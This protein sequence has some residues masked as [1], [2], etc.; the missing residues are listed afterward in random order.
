MRAGSRRGGVVLVV[1]GLLAVVLGGQRAVGQPCEGPIFRGQ[2]FRVGTD[3]FSIAVGDLT[4]DGLPDIVAANSGDNSISVLINDGLGGI[5]S[6]EDY[7]AGPNPWGVALGDIDGDGD[8]DVAAC[9]RDGQCPSVVSVWVNDGTGGLAGRVDTPVG[10]TPRAVDFGDVDG[11]GDFDLAIANDEDATATVLANDGAG[12]FTLLQTVATGPRPY[13]IRLTDLDGDGDADLITANRDGGSLTVSLNDGGVFDGG[14]NYPANAQ[15]QGLDL[16]DLDSDGDVDALVANPIDRVVSVLMNNGTGGFAAPT[17]L[18]G[19]EGASSVRAE[20]ANGDGRPDL[21][22]CGSVL[23]VWIGDGAG[24]FARRAEYPAGGTFSALA[25]GDMD[26]DGDLDALL[27]DLTAEAVSILANDGDGGFA[28]TTATAVDGGELQFFALFDL[29]GDGLGEAVTIDESRSKL[30]VYARSGE[31]FV[32]ADRREGFQSIYEAI[33]GE[34][35][36][37]D[38][39]DLVLAEQDADRVVVLPGNGDG[40][41]GSPIA[42][43]TID[44]PVFLD[45]GDMDGDGRL[46][47]V[48]LGADGL[49]V[50]LNDGGGTL[51]PAIP[52]AS[53]GEA[54]SVSV[55]DVDGDGHLDVVS[56]YGFRDVAVYLGDGTGALAF[57]GLT[58]VSS[59]PQAVTAV[60][61][62]A[63]GA[64]DVVAVHSFRGIAATLMSRGDGTLEPPVELFGDQWADLCIADIDEDGDLDVLASAY[65]SGLVSVLENDGEGVLRYTRG[66][67]SGD[68]PTKIGCVSG[69]FGLRVN[70]AVFSPDTRS[71]ELLKVSDLCHGCPADL[72]GDGALTIFD[73]L[74]FQNLF[75]LQ[76]PQADFDGDGELTI[77][78]FLAFQNAFDAGCP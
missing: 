7:P 12:G 15:A 60:D 19:G 54:R 57:A 26:G 44:G 78:D 61:L 18:D 11:D 4:G 1:L 45:R 72:D 27:G 52:V 70:V 65:R 53:S 32:I 6:R 74:E 67:L 2:S 35:S 47:V 66:F 63:D 69:V 58:R 59:E 22:A 3:P 56:R 49:A 29:N 16:A 41:V 30:W 33:A 62:N 43:A 25:S 20:D 34:F 42:T 14:A 51:G 71:I 10:C 9:A 64:A 75:D 39:A 31:D 17:T 23:H 48:V 24:G 55:G 40:T 68:G 21:L 5:T 46:D 76:D 73:F 50:H 13:A 28:A 8:L 38:N 36:G 37:D 77:F